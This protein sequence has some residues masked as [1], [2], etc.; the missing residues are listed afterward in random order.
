MTA[1]ATLPQVPAQRLRNSNLVELVNALKARRA[2]KLDVVVPTNHIRLSGG[3]L[4]VG[5]LDE[6][7]VADHIDESGVTPGFSFDPS[8]L[9]EPT[10][11]VDQHIASLF[12][13]PVRYVRKLREE[14]VELLDINVNRHADRVT[15]GS[16][17]LRLIWGSNPTDAATTGIVRAIL[18]D[19]YQI[20]D[21]LDT[22]LA[23][24]AGLKEAGLGGENVKSVDL[25]ENKLYLNIEVPEIAVHGRSLI[26]GY[27]SP[28]SGQ[29]G[30]DL[31]LV[32]A[33]LEFSN[34]ENGNGA[35][36]VT[37]KAIFQVCNNGATI[38]AFNL[39]KIHLGRKLEQGQIN[40]S[41]G[42]ITAANELVRNQVRD[43]TKSFLSTD[44]LNAAVDEWEKEAG[45]EVRKPLDVIKV[46]AKELSYTENEQEE[47]LADFIKGGQLTS[48]GIGHAITSVAQRIE[49]PDR[50]HDFAET[51]Q[52]ATSIAAR[53]AAT[54]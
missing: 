32:H 38:N 8:G 19:R 4:L 26:K 3:N 13:I 23:I 10:H 14:D 1:I 44:F 17:L 40:W 53:V 43:A 52:K 47:I 30:E 18:S 36:Q 21:H 34:S 46:V 15:T 50:S 7:K 20:I 51:H 22:V 24:L 49:D 5:G 41:K 48:G 27:R 35:F 29:S 45:V 2:Q 42:T 9:Y 54:V 28:F 33:G 25:S 16:N 11:I 31:P 37:P 12:N 6:V 39:R